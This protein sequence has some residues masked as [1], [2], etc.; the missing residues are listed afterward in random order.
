MITYFR[1]LNDLEMDADEVPDKASKFEG[2][3][4]NGNACPVVRREMGR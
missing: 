4:G 2:R 3:N 1:R